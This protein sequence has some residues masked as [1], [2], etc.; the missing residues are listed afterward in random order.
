MIKGHGIFEEFRWDTAI[1]PLWTWSASRLKDRY[2][3]RVYPPPG[4]DVGVRRRGRGG[5]RRPARLTVG[6]GAGTAQVRSEFGINFDHPASRLAEYLTVL[7]AAVDTAARPE[8]T[9]Q[10]LAGLVT[11]LSR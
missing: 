8:R 1:G 7:R 5:D 6:L 10:V 9:A 3:L 4:G 2:R 11:A